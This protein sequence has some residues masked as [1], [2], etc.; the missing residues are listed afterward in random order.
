MSESITNEALKQLAEAATSSPWQVID[1]T[2]H[3]GVYVEAELA[4]VC[5][6]YYMNDTRRPI[7]QTNDRANA[8]FIAAAREAVPRL[9]SEIEAKD[10]ELREGRIRTRMAVDALHIA[11]KTADPDVREAFAKTAFDLL[12]LP[13]DDLEPETAAALTEES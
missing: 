12:T 2:E 5:D 7:R 4:T 8:A 3:H 1:A 10:A 9:L 11:I 6:L 13:I